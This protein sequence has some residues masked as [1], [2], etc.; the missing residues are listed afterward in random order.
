[1]NRCLTSVLAIL[2]MATLGLAADDSKEA[3]AAH[4]FDGGKTQRNLD[5]GG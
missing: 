3:W 2:L 1:M 4:R 5:D